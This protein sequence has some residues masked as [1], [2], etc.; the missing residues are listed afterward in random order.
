MGTRLKARYADGG[1]VLEYVPDRD[2]A[3]HSTDGQ[4]V[5]LTPPRRGVHAVVRGA[6]GIGLLGLGILAVTYVILIATIIATPLIDGRVVVVTR[7]AH[8][9]GSVPPGTLLAVTPGPVDRS[10]WGK[11]SQITGIPNLSVV[12]VL[13]GPYDQITTSN[14]LLTVN[15]TQTQTPAPGLQP[16]WLDGEYLTE[17]V[18]GVC[19][20]ASDSTYVIVPED[21][22]VGEVKP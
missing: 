22:I 21:S 13:A 5:A 7:G 12:R 1:D 14:G 6:L 15:G 4:P 10:V 9:T 16:R 18:E 8:S 2:R 11:V 17:C 3:A 19:R 20:T